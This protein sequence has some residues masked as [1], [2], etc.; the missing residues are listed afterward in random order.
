MAQDWLDTQ[1]NVPRAKKGLLYV[2]FNDLDLDKLAEMRAQGNGKA[3]F[4]LDG[5]MS[6]N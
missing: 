3:L 4:A 1:E 6:K 5:H 2:A